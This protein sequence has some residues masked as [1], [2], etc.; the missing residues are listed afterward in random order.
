[1]QI[2]TKAAALATTLVFLAPGLGVAD[3][4]DGSDGLAGKELT[5]LEREIENARFR[6]KTKKMIFKETETHVIIPCM[7]QVIEDTPGASELAEET[8]IAALMVVVKSDQWD[9]LKEATYE[10][11][12]KLNDGQGSGLEDRKLIYDFAKESCIEGTLKSTK[13]IE[14]E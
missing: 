12:S 10:L 13:E 4:S 5:P 2:I 9:D 7:K 3:E 14:D 11:V 6:A 8:A 1:M